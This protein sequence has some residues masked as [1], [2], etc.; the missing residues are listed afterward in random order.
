M[1]APSGSSVWS[2]SS[3][4]TIYLL[5]TI[6]AGVVI[7]NIRVLLISTYRLGW[8]LSFD[9]QSPGTQRFLE[10]SVRTR[11]QKKRDTIVIAHC[12]FPQSLR[13]GEPVIGS[14]Y[15]AKVLGPLIFPDKTLKIVSCL[16]VPEQLPQ[17]VDATSEEGLRL[18][19]LLDVHLRF[20]SYGSS[21]LLKATLASLSGKTKLSLVPPKSIRPGQ[22]ENLYWPQRNSVFVYTALDNN[23]AVVG[24]L[25]TRTNRE[26]WYES[27]AG[28][29]VQF[30]TKIA[31]RAI[32]SFT[33]YMPYA[34]ESFGRSRWNGGDPSRKIERH[35]ES[36]GRNDMFK[37]RESVTR[38]VGFDARKERLSKS[39]FMA[40]VNSNCRREIPTTLIRGLFGYAVHELLNKPVHNLG[41]CPLD[42]EGAIRA[43]ITV[44]QRK[45]FAKRWPLGKGGGASAQEIFSHHKFAICF[46][47][48]D[49]DGYI[50]EKIVTPYAAMSIPVYWGG[51]SMITKVLN[52]RAFVHCE[53]PANLTSLL[54]ENRGRFIKEV[55]SGSEQSNLPC[56]K[57]VE[58]EFYERSLPFFK[59]CID[60][61]RALDE[62]DAAY[63]RMLSEPLATLDPT[64]GEL[65]GYWNET[66]YAQAIR[67]AFDSLG[68]DNGPEALRRVLEV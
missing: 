39:Y 26:S 18:L 14:E 58:E 53:L 8:T 42:P 65:T 25:I 6:I 44:Q 30:D 49:L 5:I 32:D 19:G 43:G 66:M 40:M 35:H 36:F 45:D 63:E 34:Y 3:R 37:L 55:C 41:A 50:T 9:E 38:P 52:P 15:F 62:D 59:S 60:Q 11:L 24:P 68:Y 2:L 4:W 29:G 12:V 54:K 57:Q 22:V 67:A 7:H 10:E 27:V 23:R 20:C 31:P 46:E 47:N 16:A 28:V 51:G 61:I 33:V 48:N 21:S 56:E 64:S 1:P 13:P 17:R